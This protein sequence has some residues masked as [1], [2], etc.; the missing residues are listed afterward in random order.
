MT[1]L[2]HLTMDYWVAA[3]QPRMAFPFVFFMQAREKNWVIHFVVL[4]MKKLPI[5]KMA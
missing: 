1:S 3:L 2:Y 5:F 4:L